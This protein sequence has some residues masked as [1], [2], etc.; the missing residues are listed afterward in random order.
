MNTLASMPRARTNI[1][2]VIKWALLIATKKHLGLP[3]TLAFNSEDIAPNAC[4]YERSYCAC[5]LGTASGLLL[6]G[7]SWIMEVRPL[8]IWPDFVTFFRLYNTMMVS[9]LDSDHPRSTGMQHLPLP[10]STCRHL[11]QP[12]LRHHL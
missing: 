4:R 11:Q 6:I 2:S 10:E 9:R 12:A 3:F 7:H 5:L 8:Q 1:D